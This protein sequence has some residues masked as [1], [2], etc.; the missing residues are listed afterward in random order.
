[1]S[2]KDAKAIAVIGGVATIIAAATKAEQSRGWKDIHK[3]AA[4]VG[5]VTAVDRLLRLRASTPLGVRRL[6]V[7]HTPA[8][9]RC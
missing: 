8:V 6:R 7:D 3:L 2:K 5:L 9:R 4:A 1:M